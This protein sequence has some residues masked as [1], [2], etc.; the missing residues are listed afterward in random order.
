MSTLRDFIFQNLSFSSYF[1]CIP[2]ERGF[3]LIVFFLIPVT[4]HKEG[5]SV[6]GIIF[7]HHHHHQMKFLKKKKKKH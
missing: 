4:A 2:A 1:K 3:T 5:P 7:H 6:A